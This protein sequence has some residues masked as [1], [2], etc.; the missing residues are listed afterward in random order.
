MYESSFLS[1]GNIL[2]FRDVI[3]KLIVLFYIKCLS[4]YLHQMAF[5]N[6][7]VQRIFQCHNIVVHKYVFCHINLKDNKRTMN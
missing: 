2:V 3:P 6:K 4:G 5:T 7:N 1:T